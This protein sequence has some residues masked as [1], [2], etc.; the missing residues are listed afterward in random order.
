MR[1][2]PRDFSKILF[3]PGDVRATPRAMAELSRAKVGVATLIRRHIRGDWSDDTCYEAWMD[4][5]ASLDGGLVV[6]SDYRLPETGV[7]VSIKTS[8]DRS[9]TLI[10]LHAERWEY[11]FSMF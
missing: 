8:A 7:W 5:E 6:Q 11:M 2:D 4:M 1:D 3:S 10:Y 9:E